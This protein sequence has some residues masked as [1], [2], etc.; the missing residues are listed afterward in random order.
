M[1]MFLF[2][3]RTNCII[4]FAYIYIYVCL[5]AD[6]IYIYI[7]TYIHTCAYLFFRRQSNDSCSDWVSN[8]RTWIKPAPNSWWRVSWRHFN[9]F[10]EHF[11]ALYL[12]FKV[13]A[14][15][16]VLGDWRQQNWQQTPCQKVERHWCGRSVASVKM[17]GF[18][19]RR[20]VDG[21]CRFRCW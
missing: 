17:T 19:N 2:P 12:C 7:H 15:L 18:L 20:D 10:S 5:F 6:V 21:L 11:W 16:A 9:G 8:Q 14:G 4:Y 13:C 3:L 1:C